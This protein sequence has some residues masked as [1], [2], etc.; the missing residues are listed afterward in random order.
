MGSDSCD[1]G[2]GSQIGDGIVYFN[3]IVMSN[4]VVELN[5][6]VMAVVYFC[7]I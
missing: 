3:V 7:P 2:V 6:V 5:G 1:N 4:V